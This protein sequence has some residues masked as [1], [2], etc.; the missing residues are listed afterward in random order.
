MPKK[1]RSSVSLMPGQSFEAVSRPQ[2]KDSTVYANLET[3]EARLQ[4]H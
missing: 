3:K 4:S 1:W 2:D